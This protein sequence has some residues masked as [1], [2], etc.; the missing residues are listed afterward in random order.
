MFWDAWPNA[1]DKP[2][3]FLNLSQPWLRT[4]SC[5]TPTLPHS[6]RG[7]APRPILVGVKEERVP[8]HSNVTQS[9][10]TETSAE[11][12]SDPSNA[13]TIRQ[14][15]TAA[16]PAVSHAVADNCAWSAHSPQ[17][18]GVFALAARVAMFDSTVLITGESGVGKERVARFLH[19]RSPRTRG[20][21]VGVNCGACA[22]ALLDSELF[23]HA[24]GAFTGAIQDRLGVFEAAQGGTLFLDEIG[25]ISPAMQLKLLRV[26]QERELRRVGEVKVRRFDVRLIAATNRDLLREV[27][28]ERFREDLYYRLHVIDLFVPPLRER[29]D[30]LQ[31]LAGEFLMRTASRLHRPIVGFAPRALEHMLRYAWPGNVRELE[32]AI[33]RA[34]ALAAGPR[35]E[36][37]DLPNVVR[38]ASTPEEPLGVR[39]LERVVRE[40]QRARVLET[41]ECYAGDRRRTAK[42]LGISP[43]TL[44]RK[45]RVCWNRFDGRSSRAVGRPGG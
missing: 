19:D 43:S 9:E 45:L 37:E 6:R 38:R 23:G 41:L 40:Q 16:R 36:V 34:C 28:H 35:I 33:E 32:H 20:P 5:L 39:P 13:V 14:R 42:A 21:F 18:R 17:M 25:D 10:R 12:A 15:E 30:D 2:S 11:G 29:P 31:A 7:Q 26:V 24:R 1:P 4:R 8:H 44:K 3:A 27:A 22:D